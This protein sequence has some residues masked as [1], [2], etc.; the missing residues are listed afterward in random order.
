M[1]SLEGISAKTRAELEARLVVPPTK[2]ELKRR[3]TDDARAERM[4]LRTKAEALEAIE[5]KKEASESQKRAAEAEQ[6]RADM[7]RNVITGI[8]G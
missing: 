3:R 6:R 4:L 8:V 5:A 2:T 1:S 7:Y